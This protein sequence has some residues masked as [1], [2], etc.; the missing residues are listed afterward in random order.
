MKIEIW[1]DVACP[2]CY[3]GKAHLDK[4]LEQL[5]DT[6]A[7]IIWRSFELDPNA[8]VEPEADIYDIL[9]TKYGKDRNWAIEMNNNMTQM[10]ENAGLDFNMD[11]VKPTNTFN[12]HRLIH[13]AKSNGL[14]NEMKERL[15]RAYFTEGI[16]IGDTTK[17]AELAA[18]I[19]L[20]KD[21]TLQTLIG[22]E[23]TDEVVEDIERAHKI[24]VQGVPFFLINN[25]YGLSGAQ[26]VETFK[27]ALKKIQAGS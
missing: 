15:L 2:F 7:D 27:N 11:E 5:A 19:G 16:N 1:S 24:G 3:I 21:A 10:A 26:P 22:K 23:Y 13:F 6:D 25:K 17:L 9:A 18:D 4:A 8:P 12:A 20:D 14:Q